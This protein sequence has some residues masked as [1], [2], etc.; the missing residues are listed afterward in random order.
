M[1]IHQ[2]IANLRTRLSLLEG[3][4]GPIITAT[5]KISTGA[6]IGVLPLHQHNG[7]GAGGATLIPTIFRLPAT[8]TDPAYVDGFA[9]IYFYSTGGVDELRVR[10]K[11]GGTETQAVLAN[12][13]P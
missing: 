9:I 4:I 1:D 5:G 13:S 6:L 7:T 12:L 3:K 8:A 2:T 10:G 11:V